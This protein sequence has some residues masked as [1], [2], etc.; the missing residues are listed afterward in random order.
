MAYTQGDLDAIKSA[1]ATGAL[2]VEY[3]GRRTTYRSL[4]D[5]RTIIADIERE[6]A[7]TSATPARTVG[8]FSSGLQST[9]IDRRGRG[10]CR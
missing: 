5:M 8:V 3:N 2:S 7:G 10:Y 1:Y 4:D 6:L 9:V